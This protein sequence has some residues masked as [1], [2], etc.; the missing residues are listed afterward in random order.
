MQRKHSTEGIRLNTH[1]PPQP[2]SLQKAHTED[3]KTAKAC[4]AVVGAGLAGLTCA[5]LLKD[6]YQ[7]TLFE[8]QTSVGMGVFSQDYHSNNEKTRIDIPLRIFTAGYYPDLFRLYQHLGIELENSDHS[9]LFQTS[10]KTAPSTAKEE[11]EPQVTPFFQYSNFKIASKHISYLNNNSLNLNSLKLL[12]GFYQFRKQINIDM[13]H[14][15]FLTRLT[16][17]QYIKHQDFN[18]DFIKLMLVPALAV[19]CTCQPNDI[20]NY[21]AKILIE[22]LTCGV[23]QQGIVRAKQGV[24]AIVPKLT[25]GYQI[26]CSQQ[27]ISAQQLLKNKTQPSSIEVK[28]VIQQA[29]KSTSEKTFDHVIFAT[30]A[31]ISQKILAQDKQSLLQNEMAQ[32]LEQI[33][34]RH[35]SMTLHCDDSV[36]F[37]A[38]KAS[39][40]S[41]IVSKESGES[42]TSVDLSKAFSTYQNQARV[43][44]TW[45]AP[46]FIEPSKILYKADFTRPI[47]SLK[48]LDAVEQLQHLNKSSAIKIAGSFMTDKIPLLDAAVKS[49]LEVCQQLE[50][51]PPWHE[52]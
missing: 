29:D 14:S 18:P 43:Y 12:I 32:Q 5:W 7:V 16:F 27:I 6:K 11:K 41:Y 35:S 9:A 47:V 3:E 49:A 2:E 33:N 26:Q 46:D 50:C 22:Y 45:N 23:L 28:L 25:Q 30:P 42:S 8:S 52:D 13:T 4:V 17:G 36:V 19:T 31:H 51:L 39:P 37:N 44:Q 48:S 24:D 15:Q 10:I 20:Y 38:D 34:I 21:P 40:V 1:T